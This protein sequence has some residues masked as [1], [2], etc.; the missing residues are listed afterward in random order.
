MRQGY[1]FFVGLLLLLG[2]QAALARDYSGGFLVGTQAF[3]WREY[4]GGGNRLLKEN[5]SRFT[6]GG[7]YGNLTAAPRGWIYRADGDIYFGS[8]DY[9]GQTQSGLPVKTD[10]YYS[11]VRVQGIGGYRFGIGGTQ[12]FG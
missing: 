11:G 6:L 5:G 12:T 9:D 2:A 8:V 1:R 4:D 7:F 3:A 10:V